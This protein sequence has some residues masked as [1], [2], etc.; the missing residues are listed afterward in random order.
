MPTRSPS[1]LV[2]PLVLVDDHERE[3]FAATLSLPFVKLTGK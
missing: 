2:A 1:Q 3:V